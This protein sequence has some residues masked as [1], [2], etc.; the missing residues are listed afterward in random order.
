MAFVPPLVYSTTDDDGTTHF[1]FNRITLESY[2]ADSEPIHS[3]M[4]ANFFRQVAD[5]ES[6]NATSPDST[7]QIIEHRQLAE[8]LAELYNV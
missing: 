1:S 7:P 8:L 6:H 2:R 4:A 3:H 5:I